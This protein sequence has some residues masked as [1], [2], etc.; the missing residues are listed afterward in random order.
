MFR[1]ILMG[2]LL[3]VVF[4]VGCGTHGERVEFGRTGPMVAEYVPKN[5]VEELRP[6]YA[7]LGSLWVEGSSLYSDWK[8]RKVGDIV[9][10]VVNEMAIAQDNGDTQTNKDS[11]FSNTIKELF[12]IKDTIGKIFGGDKT[13][14]IDLSSKYGYKGGGKISQQSRFSTKISA[15]VT[16]VL[17]NGNLV[18]EGK[19]ALFINGER[20]IIGIRGVVRPQDISSDNTVSSESVADAE[21]VY[22]GKG[23]VSKSQNPGLFTRLLMVFWPFF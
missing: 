5:N 12:G 17:P 23:I 19:R 1:F 3:G 4:L 7:S 16:E 6:R 2:I 10:I 9:T 22:E 14:P 8:A 13:N 21:I 11:S 18:V 15:V 20:K